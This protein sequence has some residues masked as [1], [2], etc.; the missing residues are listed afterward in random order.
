MEYIKQHEKRKKKK[1]EKERET[2][3]LNYNIFYLL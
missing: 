1:I 3:S 2:I